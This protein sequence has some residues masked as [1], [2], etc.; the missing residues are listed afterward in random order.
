MIG[1]MICPPV[2]ATASTSAAKAGR[3][4]LRFISGMVT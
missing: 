1:G 3:K 2:L 4:P